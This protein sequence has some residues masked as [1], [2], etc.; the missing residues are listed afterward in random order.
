MK[1]ITYKEIAHIMKMKSFVDD[2]KGW[3]RRFTF[4]ALKEG[5]LYIG[6]RIEGSIGKL[7]PIEFEHLDEWI[8]YF[9]RI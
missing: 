3:T 5:K 6:H 9:D 8:K 7:T 4:I 2:I 1:E